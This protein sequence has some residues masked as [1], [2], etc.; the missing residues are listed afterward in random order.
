[1][2]TILKKQLS[3]LCGAAVLGGALLWTSGSTRAQDEDQSPARRRLGMDTPRISLTRDQAAKEFIGLLEQINAPMR[4]PLEGEADPAMLSS[5]SRS[6]ET[7]SLGTLLAK[8]ARQWKQPLQV[9][10][11]QEENPES[12]TV[13]VEDAPV[14]TPRPLILIREGDSWGVDVLETY[15]KWNGL[16]GQAKVDAI[17]RLTGAVNRAQSNARRA[18]C[19]SNLKQIALGLMQYVQDYDEKLPPAKGWIDLLQPYVKSEQIFKCPEVTDSKGFGYAYN[20]KLSQKSLEGLEAPAFTTAI[21]ETTVLKRN[22]Y[23]MGENRAFRHE[24]GAN[25]AFADGHVKW[26][27]KSAT[28]PSFNLKPQIPAEWDGAE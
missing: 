3:L 28:N 5:F 27:E 22:A 6:S 26:Y 2:T 1:M 9:V 15:A 13:T 14:A 23:G 8:M 7:D 10:K 12:A 16:E 18:S 17:A 24:G 21:Y 25:Y 11:V 4:V 19:Q 20:S